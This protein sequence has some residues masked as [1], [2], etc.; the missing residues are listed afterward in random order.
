MFLVLYPW[1]IDYYTPPQPVYNPA[2]AAMK[3]SRAPE[4]L[5]MAAVSKDEM[6]AESAPVPVEK[7]IGETTV[8]FDVSVPCSVPPTARSDC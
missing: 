3:K 1:F 7:K 6:A 8:T 5:E 2:R 4:A